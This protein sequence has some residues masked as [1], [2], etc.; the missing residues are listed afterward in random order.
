L[1]HSVFARELQHASAGERLVS[2]REL[3]GGGE[4]E[5]DAV[6]QFLPVEVWSVGSFEI[7]QVEFFAGA[8]LLV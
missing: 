2:L 6:G 7:G 1:T 4:F 5:A 8:G 3:G